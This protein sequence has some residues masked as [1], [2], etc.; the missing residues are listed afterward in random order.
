MR[1]EMKRLFIAEKPAIANDLKT[2]IGEH[3]EKKNG[4]FESDKTLITWC[5]GHIIES[6]PPEGYNPQYATWRSEDLPLKMFP[7]IYQPKQSAAGHVEIVLDLIK[8]EDVSVICNACDIDDE[9]SLIFQEVMEFSG[10]KKPTERIFI[11]D[12]TTPAIQKALK[13]LK[14]NSASIGQYKKG[15]ARQAA[16]QV[17]GMSMSRLYT[18]IAKEKGY[19]GVMS[20]GRVQTPVL[21]LIVNRFKENQS[22]SKSFYYS[23]FAD[24]A[25]NGGA[26]IP[27]KLKPSEYAP[28]DDKQRITDEQYANKLVKALNAIESAE[29]TAAAT[30]D[31]TT[32]APLPFNLA[33]LQQ[34]MN[35]KF[36]MTAQQTLD[37]T[38]ELRE[39]HKAITYN[40][41]DCSYLSDDQYAEAPAVVSNL[42]ALFSADLDIDAA[43]KSPAFNPAKVTAHTAIIPTAKVPD[44]N[45]LSPAQKNVY[46]AIAEFYLAQFM[47][48]K[49]YQEA[50]AQIKIGQESFT[51][52]ATTTTDKGFTALLSGTDSEE[53]SQDNESAGNFEQISR[54]QTGQTIKHVQAT[55]T[56]SETKPPM[57]FTEASLISALTRIADFV[58]DP[59]IKALLKAKDADKKDEHGGIGTPATRAAIIETLK[60]RNFIADQKGKL[61]PTEAGLALI[62]SLPA[63]L[64]APDQTALWSEKQNDIENGKLSVDEFINDLYTEITD[65]MANA[66]LTNL[67]K[68]ISGGLTA[69]C[70]SCGQMLRDTPKTLN[71][72]STTCQFTLWKTQFN[73]VL[74]IQQLDKLL[75]TG[76]TPLIKGFKSSAGKIFDAVITLEDKS[77]GKTKPVFPKAPEI[78]CYICNSSCR[79]NDKGLFCSSDDCLK[80]WRVVASKKLTD[81]QLKTLATKGKTGEIKG[82]TKKDGSEFDAIILIDKATKKTSFSFNKK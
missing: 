2:A 52:R 63:S 64:T 29:V 15:L 42:K 77:T 27:T 12:N 21:G 31:K 54:L 53:E 45:N 34:H 14:P 48:K 22:H 69:P 33:R 4:F 72:S 35:R 58:T 10:T 9:G 67:D 70:P 39:K 44:L 79:L 28:V 41:S 7:L 23:V 26:S 17:F 32:A 16:D 75:K 65:L 78:K 36:K 61:I 76:E 18:L 66:T 81:T 19:S 80:L 74:T 46:L 5:Y 20:V 73:K 38:Q 13:N 43:R 30:D 60:K 82:F 3:F 1:F 59:Q 37:V 55:V 6:V 11:S 71:C 24:V 49:A 50:S 25:K 8:R 51:C 56:K 47:P 40:R 57:L 62:D 68:A